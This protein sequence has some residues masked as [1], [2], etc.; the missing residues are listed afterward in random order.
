MQPSG[1]GRLTEWEE[2]G[3]SVSWGNRDYVM[4]TRVEGREGSFPL[5]T[6]VS[7]SIVLELVA[8]LIKIHAVTTGVG[9]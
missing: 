8:H 6:G 7:E 9:T 2:R 3:R 1:C 5:P 4:K